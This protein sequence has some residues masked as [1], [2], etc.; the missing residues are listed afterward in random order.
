M[1]IVVNNVGGTDNYA[2]GWQYIVVTSG[3]GCCVM[4]IGGDDCKCW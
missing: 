2:D 1:V 4:V 3:G